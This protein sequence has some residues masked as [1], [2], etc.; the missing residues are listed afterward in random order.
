MQA[1]GLKLT[2]TT[3]AL[4]QYDWPERMDLTTEL[5]ETAA[6]QTFKAI[7]ECSISKDN[8]CQYFI[9][10]DKEAVG[11]ASFH[12]F[13]EDE[14]FG[15]D[16]HLWMGNCSNETL[17]KTITPRFTR[18]GTAIVELAVRLLYQRAPGGHIRLRSEHGSA[19]FYYKNGFK[20]AYH[21]AFKWDMDFEDEQEKVEFETAHEAYYLAKNTS[22]IQTTITA[23]TSTQFYQ[24]LIQEPSIQEM[25]AVASE[26][27]LEDLAP[28]DFLTHGFGRDANR[29]LAL[30]IKN[31]PDRAPF[32][33][34]GEMYLPKEEMRALQQ[35]L[36]L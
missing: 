2:P 7:A 5:V 30:W 33:F 1:D 26:K 13:D 25:T 14:L 16:Q 27:S 28:E 35:R 9:Y 19:P 32:A 23:L 8:E 3:P 10:R 11:F 24:R 20:I 18:V 31:Q 15:H 36:F 17:E 6:G 4:L 22:D 29:E 34:R 21:D 12:Y